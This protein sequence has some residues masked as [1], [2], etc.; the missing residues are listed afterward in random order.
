VSDTPTAGR[1]SRSPVMN[2]NLKTLWPQFAY[3][4][5]KK[6]RLLIIA[7]LPSL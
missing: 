5:N 2:I 3:V 1:T 6:D 4:V 7:C